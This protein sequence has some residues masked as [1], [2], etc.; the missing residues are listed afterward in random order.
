M[1][2][3]KGSQYCFKLWKLS[4]FCGAPKCINSA[5]LFIVWLAP[6]RYPVFAQQVTA[7]KRCFIDN[8]SAIIPFSNFKASCSCPGSAINRMKIVAASPGSARGHKP[9]GVPA[10]NAF[11]FNRRI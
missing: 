3:L 2:R 11:G 1:H 8:G 6:I 5:D 9:R 4:C 7:D 10:G